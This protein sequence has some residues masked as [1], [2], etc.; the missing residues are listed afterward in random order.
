MLCEHSIRCL[1]GTLQGTLMSLCFDHDLSRDFSC[2][3]SHLS[4]RGNARKVPNLTSL[5]TLDF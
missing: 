2:G 4:Y 3:I 1:E 5:Q